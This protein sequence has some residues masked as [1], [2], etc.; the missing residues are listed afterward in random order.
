MKKSVIAIIIKMFLPDDL[1][2]IWHL[3]LWCSN[4]VSKFRAN[5]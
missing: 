2:T 4:F 5:E 1:S 3:T